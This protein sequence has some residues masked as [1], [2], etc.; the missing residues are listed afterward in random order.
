MSSPFPSRMVQRPTSRSA[1]SPTIPMRPSRNSWGSSVDVPKRVRAP[2]RPRHRCDRNASPHRSNRVDRRNGHGGRDAST[3]RY[4]RPTKSSSG[5]RESTCALHSAAVL[6][7]AREG[8][9]SER[10]SM[11]RRIPASS[12]PNPSRG[13]SRSSHASLSPRQ[14]GRVPGAPL[15]WSAERSSARTRFA[16]CSESTRVTSRE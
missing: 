15:G 7:D 4:D 3:C 6:R 10:K 16:R 14:S 2:Y 11:S 9:A 8:P 13:S 1:G 5:T 12:I